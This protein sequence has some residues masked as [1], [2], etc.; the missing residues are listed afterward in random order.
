MYVTRRY[1]YVALL[2]ITALVAGVVV[3]HWYKNIPIVFQSALYTTTNPQI[4]ERFAHS[5]VHQ[6]GWNELIPDAEK[7]LI[8]RYQLPSSQDFTE[9]VLLSIQA[10]S[11]EEYKS[12]L[13]S[14]NVV[15][16][17]IGRAVSISGFIVP[18]EV[19]EDRSIRSFFLVPYYGACIHYPPPPP[20]Q[21]I[22]VALEDVFTQYNMQQAYTVEG[23]LNRG[24]FEDPMGTSAYVLEVNRITSFQG[25][26][27][28]F[29]EH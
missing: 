20:N 29:R 9:Q 27:D 26:P 21:I 13:I 10:N 3:G 14:T 5:Q 16:D 11:D 12:A 6:L 17:V 19:S 23:I 4:I 15:E 25:Q 28:D 7:K 22:Y 24:M 8:E 18:L 2:L 1:I